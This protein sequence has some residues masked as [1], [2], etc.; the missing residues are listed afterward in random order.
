VN[1]E[2]AQ[3]I[4]TGPPGCTEPPPDSITCTSHQTPANTEN[5]GQ[6]IETY[7][8]CSSHSY[9]LIHSVYFVLYK[10]SCRIATRKIQLSLSFIVGGLFS[11]LTLKMEQLEIQCRAPP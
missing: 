1:P 9:P 5:H 6:E 7:T 8:H 11:V 10:S 4:L 3:E 2:A